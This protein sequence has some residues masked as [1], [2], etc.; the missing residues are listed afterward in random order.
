M[1]TPG[2]AAATAK[3]IGT[4]GDGQAENSEGQIRRFGG[5]IAFCLAMHPVGRVKTPASPTDGM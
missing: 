5:F 4:I 3:E 1:F 2:G